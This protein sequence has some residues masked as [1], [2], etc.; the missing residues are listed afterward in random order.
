M[1]YSGGENHIGGVG[2]IMIIKKIAKSV[3]GLWAVSNRMIQMKIAAK[4]FDISLIQVYASTSD[5]EMKE[6][7]IF[8]EQPEVTMKQVKSDEIL[9]L[10]GDLKAKVGK[11]RCTN[12][13]GN[14][15][16]GKRN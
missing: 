3:K 2:I 11:G 5:Y 12:I 16:L 15:G 7:E 4:T 10:V 14:W 8:Y 6:I 13:V 9:I 1:I